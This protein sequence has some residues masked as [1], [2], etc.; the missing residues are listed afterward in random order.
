MPKPLLAL[1]VA[2]IAMLLMPAA[3]MASGH[4]STD[5]LNYVWKD[6]FGFDPKWQNSPNDLVVNVVLPTFAIFIITLGFMRVLPIFQGSDNIE[7]SIA[8]LVALSA[9]FTGAVGWLNTWALAFLGQL[10]FVLFFI[11]FLVGSILYTKGFLKKQSV[12][13]KLGAAYKQAE[14]DSIKKVKAYEEKLAALDK[15]IAETPAKLKA[16][17]KE[18]EIQPTL[19]KL[20]MKRETTAL[21]LL[22]EK[23]ARRARKEGIEEITN[24]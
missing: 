8:I 3:V 10:A 15:E 21:A 20:E 23:H 13:S 4:W 5:P 7:Y 1:Q 18:N 12:A 6:L 24:T 11:M 17:N 19:S 14:L 22:E 16:Q 2:V 9:M